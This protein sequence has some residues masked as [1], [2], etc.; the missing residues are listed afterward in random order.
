MIH[1]AGQPPGAIF[2]T[3][4]SIAAAEA[5]APF[6]PS[7]HPRNLLKAGRD[8]CPAIPTEVVDAVTSACFVKPDYQNN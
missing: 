7:L 6:L 2:V 8:T 5:P 3:S 1:G 4:I